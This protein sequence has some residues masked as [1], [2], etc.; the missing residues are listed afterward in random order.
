MIRILNVSAS[1]SA[2]ASPHPLL[3]IK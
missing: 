1:A 2:P 3:W